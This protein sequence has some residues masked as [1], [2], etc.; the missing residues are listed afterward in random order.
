MAF[1]AGRAFMT[2][3]FTGLAET[4]CAGWGGSRKGPG[5]RVCMRPIPVF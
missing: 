4:P 3:G 1:G 2:S 5:R